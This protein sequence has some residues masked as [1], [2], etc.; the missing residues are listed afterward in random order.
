MSIAQKMLLVAAGNK[1]QLT[2]NVTPNYQQAFTFGFDG[3]YLTKV[4]NANIGI[5]SGDG[6]YWTAIGRYYPADR[7]AVWWSGNAGFGNWSRF[8]SSGFS[9][10]F[11]TDI[12]DVVY[13]V[14]EDTGTSGVSRTGDPYILIGGLFGQGV[15]SFNGTMWTRVGSALPS[16]QFVGAFSGDYWTK[17]AVYRNIT[18][19]PN[20]FWIIAISKKYN[21][22]AYSIDGGVTWT[23]KRQITVSSTNS[24]IVDIKAIRPIGRQV[25]GTTWFY[26]VSS[27]ND[28][29]NNPNPLGSYYCASGQPS[30]TLAWT[31]VRGLSAT[32]NGSQQKF[33]FWNNLTYDNTLN[34]LFATGEKGSPVEGQIA[35]TSL[36]AATEN[37]FGFP[38]EQPREWFKYT[39]PWPSG[40]ILNH[41]PNV[42]A[43]DCQTISGGVAFGDIIA[44]GD[45]INNQVPPNRVALFV[46]AGSATWRTDIQKPGNWIVT[47][48]INPGFAMNSIAT[49]F[50]VN[51]PTFTKPQ[52]S[53]IAVNRSNDTLDWYILDF[54]YYPNQ[55]KFAP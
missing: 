7:T 14:G 32:Y 31:I 20:R 25:S 9:D 18:F 23:T 27:R 24:L 50:T 1:Q 12:E 38:T 21:W 11:D 5:G 28:P 45:S 52:I 22:F 4:I 42:L 36:T 49:A 8:P 43:S 30:S 41:A 46:N 44:P 13:S 10:S 48:P 17:I 55:I 39:P 6:R 3:M 40:Y 26:R 53:L 29:F 16:T 19:S 34:V 51:Y 15:Y 37:S 2:W 35:Y 54:P 33:N 47:A